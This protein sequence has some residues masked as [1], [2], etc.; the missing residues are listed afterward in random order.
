DTARQGIFR[1]FPN[2][3]N[4]NSD[5]AIPTI[6]ILGNPMRPTAATGDLRSVVLFSQDPRRPTF[7]PTGT[8]QKLLAMMPS[9]NDFRFGDGLNTTSYTW[10]R[11]SD[12]DFNQVNLR[13]DHNLNSRHRATF[14]FT[15]EDVN[16]PNGFM[17]QTFPASPGGTQ[18]DAG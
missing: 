14:T 15:H 11:R 7:D 17:G 6:D 9:P 16:A 5:A 8:V 2:V 1:F 12:P 13:I 18:N 3:Q 10:K 4:G